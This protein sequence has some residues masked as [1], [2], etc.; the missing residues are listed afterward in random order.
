MI[1]A[2]AAF[3]L[4]FAFLALTNRPPRDERD[5]RK[6]A[7]RDGLEARRA[8]QTRATDRPVVTTQAA[9]RLQAGSGPQHGTNGTT[10]ADA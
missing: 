1:I 5:R 10:G 6:R 7:R 2:L 3:I 8:L 4:S 9:P